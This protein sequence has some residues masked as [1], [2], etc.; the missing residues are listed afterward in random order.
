MCVVVGFVVGTGLR[1]LCCR[2]VVVV[3]IV[4]VIV[5]AIVVAIVVEGVAW[6]VNDV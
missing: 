3:V 2:K 1:T 6:T 5:V 4:V